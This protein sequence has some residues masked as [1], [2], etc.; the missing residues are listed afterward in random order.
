[1]LYVLTAQFREVLV[2][3]AV[4]HDWLTVYSGAEKVLE[5]I[6]SLY[7][8]AD[9]FT[10]FDFLP[11]EQRRYL[12]EHR[13]STSFLQNFPF[14]K[15]H[16][17]FFLALMPLAIEQF[18]FSD[19]D[20]VISSSHAV[21]KGVITGPNQLHISYV[22][23][24]IRYAWDL[25]GQYLKEANLTKGLK[26]WLARWQLHK[27][28]LWDYRTGAGVDYYA[29]NSRFIAKRIR[30]IYG[31]DAQVIYPPVDVEDFQLCEQ[32][33]HYYVTAQRM[34]PYKKV[35]L[36]VEA[37]SQMPDKELLVLGDGPGMDKVRKA[38]TTPNIKILGYQSK[39]DLVKLVGEAKAFVFAAEEDFGI[40][41]VEAQACGTPVLAYGAGG[42]LE[43][44]ED[45]CTGLFF[46][47][48]SVD[49]IIEAVERFEQEGV[50]YSA[51]QIRQ[52]A[53]KFSQQRFIKAFSALV[54][55]ASKKEC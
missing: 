10:L 22:H 26:S 9:V 54:E 16:Y 15:T 47:H 50:R 32:K 35:A 7:P 17:R 31:R 41:P 46:Q 49:S 36:I 25:Q 39:E 20:L 28:R 4:V 40:A 8:E 2:K 48:Q 12:R 34:V 24:P 51:A 37:F 21:A 53:L 55:S 29:A 1:M 33:K 6:L 13:I 18:D 52:A 23:S 44:V 42:A 38:A 43:T 3:V 30:K 5:Q 45:G 14:A 27:I 11:V 19:Y